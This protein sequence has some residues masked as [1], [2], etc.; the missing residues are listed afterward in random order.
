MNSL[1]LYVSIGHELADIGRKLA[2]AAFRE[3][4]AFYSK[5]DGSP[6][7]EV[8]QAVEKA[9]RGVITDNFPEHGIL[10]EE[11]GNSDLDNE[12]VWVIDPIDGTKN[13][14]AG[15][16]TFGCLISL[17]R[18][19]VPVLGIIELPVAEQRCVG[20]E[21]QPTTFND[22]PVQCRPRQNLKECVMSLS[23][24]E[25]FKGTAPRHRL[26]QLWPE[27]EWNVY[28][29]GCAGYASLS[30]GY[31]DLC[32]DG[33]NLSPYDFCAF[34]PVVA[35]AGGRITDWQ[36]NALNLH[37]G[38]AIRAKGVLAS[39]DPRT[40]EQALRCLNE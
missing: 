24:H 9:M 28:G 18:N 29:G 30:R 19:G 8:D 11:Y 35:G 16:P 40:H 4:A 26:E 7:T 15:L 34:V 38:P 37:A 22:K 12:F 21:G 1:N 17:C 27:T 10:G 39:G 14:A 36:G 31:V 2:R 33:S 5:S 20:V 23:G 25:Y 13:F 3:G 32:L 6:V